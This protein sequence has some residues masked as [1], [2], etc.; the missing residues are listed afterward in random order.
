MILRSHVKAAREKAKSQAR[1]VSPLKLP[2]IR[3]QPVIE[4]RRAAKCR[5]ASPLK[6]S[7]N[8]IR[9]DQQI[10][11]TD[12]E[13]PSTSQSQSVSQSQTQKKQKYQSASDTEKY[14]QR[15]RRHHHHSKNRKTLPT[16]EDRASSPSKPLLIAYDEEPSFVRSNSRRKHGRIEETSRLIEY[17]H[18]EGPSTSYCNYQAPC[19]Q[20][21]NYNPY[22][23]LATSSCDPE[24]STKNVIAE[25]EPSSRKPPKSAASTKI[26]RPPQQKPSTSKSDARHHSTSPPKT[27]C[28]SLFKSLHLRFDGEIF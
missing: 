14:S 2:S 20:Y 27:E 23:Q 4:E 26:P 24:N 5:S 16:P 22:A 3:V 28:F 8:R 1:S 11:Y 7:G 25:P 15:P 6:A 21:S 9:R 19:D 18:C 13:E 10:N 17:D 12:Y